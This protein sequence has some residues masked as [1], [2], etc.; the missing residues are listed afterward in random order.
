M[1]GESH[2]GSMQRLP[3]GGDPWGKSDVLRLWVPFPSSTQGSILPSMWKVGF[4]KAF[5]YYF[6]FHPSSRHSHVDVDLR[7]QTFFP[8]IIIGMWLVSDNFI[9]VI[10]S[11]IRN[12]WSNVIVSRI[13]YPDLLVDS[14]ILNPRQNMKFIV[15]LFSSFLEQL[16][17]GTGFVL[18]MNGW[19]HGKL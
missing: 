6:C 2:W 8:C 16:F 5:R 3:A 14:F 19:T 17:G 1:V 15:L 10:C 9:T 13:L 12:G 4:A 11:F 7:W 18:F